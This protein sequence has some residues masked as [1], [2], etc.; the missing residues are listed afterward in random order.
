LHAGGNP[1]DAQINGRHQNLTIAGRS[2]PMVN[3]KLCILENS[4]V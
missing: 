2:G 1:F 3:L 4:G